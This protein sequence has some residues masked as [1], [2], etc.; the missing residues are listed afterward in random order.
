M[1]L[2]IWSTNLTNFLTLAKL[3]RAE[4][5]TPSVPTLQPT[6]SSLAAQ[7]GGGGW[8]GQSSRGLWLPMCW[9]QGPPPGVTFE[10]C[11]PRSI[12]STI[13][14]GHYPIYKSK[15]GV[16][17]SVA[18]NR[19]G[20]GGQGRHLPTAGHFQLRL[21]KQHLL[22]VTAHSLRSFPDVT[23]FRENKN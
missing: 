16:C 10:A 9:R 17:L 18:T 7:R 3:G 12:Y 19:A 8:A 23:D 5:T 13:H 11:C 14:D 1:I 15:H 4:A 2:P 6:A 21:V 22:P 20:Q